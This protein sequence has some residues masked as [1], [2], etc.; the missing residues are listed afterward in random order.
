VWA[1][2]GFGS[3]RFDGTPPSTPYRL[4]RPSDLVEVFDRFAAVTSGI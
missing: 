1:A 4:D 2:Y 3:A